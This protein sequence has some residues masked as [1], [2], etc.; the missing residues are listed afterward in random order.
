MAATNSLA[1]VWWAACA[2]PSMTRI[3][4]WARR[5][6]R[7]SVPMRN[8]ER[9][10]EPSRSRTGTE[11]RPSASIEASGLDSAST[12]RRMVCAASTRAGHTGLARYASSSASDM[13]TIPARNVVSAASLSPRSIAARTASTR[14]G[15]L[16]DMPGGTG[17]PS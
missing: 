14:P 17:A 10:L 13:P 5:A 3:S 16:Y 11:T 8:G 2:A 1:W 15:G 9:L 12:S 6:A 7:A 4:A